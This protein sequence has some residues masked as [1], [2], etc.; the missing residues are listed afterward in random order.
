M[1][2]KR[3]YI[4]QSGPKTVLHLVLS[5]F[6]EGINSKIIKQNKLKKQNSPQIYI[7]IKI[8]LNMLKRDQK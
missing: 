4:S 5:V 8:K 3:E 6:V 1:G 7:S 2:R